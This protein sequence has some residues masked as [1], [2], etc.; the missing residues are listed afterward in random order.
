[1][2][3]VYMAASSTDGARRLASPSM[4]YDVSL[5]AFVCGRGDGQC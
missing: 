4:R 2:Q 3:R 1:V 5:E